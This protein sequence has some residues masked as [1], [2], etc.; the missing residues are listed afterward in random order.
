LVLI[1]IMASNKQLMGD[2]HNS[3]LSTTLGWLLTGLMACT[4]VAAI[5]SLFP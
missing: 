4:G 1:V 3:R 5:Y 2:W